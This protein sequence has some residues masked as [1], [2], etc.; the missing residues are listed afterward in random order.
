MEE[1]EFVIKN[2]TGLH[3]R[4]ASLFV[5]IANNFNADIN[6]FFND[7]KYNAKSIISV[8]SAGVGNDGK[9]KISAAGLDESVAIETIT[10]FFM[11]EITE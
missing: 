4:P 1:R 11:H 9:I 5:K 3:A 8:L 10:T 2:K 6:M 7:K